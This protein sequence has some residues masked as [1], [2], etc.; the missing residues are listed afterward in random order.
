LVSGVPRHWKT[1]SPRRSASGSKHE[2]LRTRSWG[3]TDGTPRAAPSPAPRGPALP[4]LLRAARPALTVRRS[5][6][7]L[8]SRARAATGARAGAQEGRSQLAPGSRYPPQ[9]RPWGHASEEGRW[10]R[11][12]AQGSGKGRT[13]VGSGMQRPHRLAEDVKRHSRSHLLSSLIDKIICLPLIPKGERLLAGQKALVK[14]S[15]P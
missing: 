7:W 2:S 11:A 10:P 3:A 12:G 6:G 9:P 14:E 1:W 8:V 5:Q 4:A 13:Q 15:E